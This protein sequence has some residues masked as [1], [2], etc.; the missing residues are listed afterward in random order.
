MTNVK[1]V[2]LP[3]S[4][5]DYYIWV[6]ALTKQTNLKVEILASSASYIFASICA[7]ILAMISLMSF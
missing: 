6:G 4:E 5:Y 1:V 2:L 3:Q 7:S